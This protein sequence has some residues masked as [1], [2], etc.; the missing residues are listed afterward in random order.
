MV[1]VLHTPVAADGLRRL[2]CTDGRGADIKGGFLSAVPQAVF[3]A[4]YERRS[5]DSDYACDEAV[6]CGFFQCGSGVENLDDAG[7]M[8]HA[9]VRIDG[10]V[11]RQGR[12]RHGGP[13]DFS[14]QSGLIFLNLDKQMAFHLA[15]RQKGFFDSAWRPA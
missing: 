9:L 1:F 14:Q 15:G 3:G 6:P 13:V 5:C 4:A 11:A 12:T 2:C 8:A 7:L 10:L